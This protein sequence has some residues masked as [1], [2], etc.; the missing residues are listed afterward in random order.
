MLNMGKIMKKFISI[1]PA[2]GPVEMGPCMAKNDK[3]KMI[4]DLCRILSVRLRIYAKY[5][6][7][8]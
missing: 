6:K 8:N 1:I 3:N 7:N 5:G 2:R 4:S